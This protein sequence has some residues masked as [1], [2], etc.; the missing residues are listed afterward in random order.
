M[1]MRKAMECLAPYCVRKF[2]SGERG[3]CFECGRALT[4]GGLVF[5]RRTFSDQDYS[6]YTHLECTFNPT[7]VQNHVVHAA[8]GLSESFSVVTIETGLGPF[9]KGRIYQHFNDPK[10]HIEDPSFLLGVRLNGQ[11]QPAKQQP[12]RLEYK[13]AL[14][15][16]VQCHMCSVPISEEFDVRVGALVGNTDRYSKWC[17]LRCWKMP[18][19][20]TGI[21]GRSFQRLQHDR[22][23]SEAVAI[24]DRLMN[25]DCGR[26]Y[27]HLMTASNHLPPPPAAPPPPLVLRVEPRVVVVAARPRVAASSGADEG[28]E[29]DHTVVDPAEAAETE[30]CDMDRVDGVQ[31]LEAGST[32]LEEPSPV[33]PQFTNQLLSPGGTQLPSVRHSPDPFDN[34]SMEEPSAHLE[35]QFTNPPVRHSPDPYDNHSMGDSSA[36]PFF[37]ATSSPTSS[38][39]MMPTTPTTTRVDRVFPPDAFAHF[40]WSKRFVLSG[41]FSKFA[42][43]SDIDT[44]EEGKSRVCDAIQNMGGFVTKKITSDT[45][46]L[47]VGAA[48]GRSKVDAANNR[49]IPILSLDGLREVARGIS[50]Q[51]A[52]RAPPVLHY[53]GG[54]TGNKRS[55]DGPSDPSGPSHPLFSGRPP[56]GRL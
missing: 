51:D 43:A 36:P 3:N 40:L 21:V 1:G 18:F 4:L 26:V 31:E 23:F 47:I 48:P 22:Q 2:S 6:D 56:R 14:E 33:I 5:G 55:R 42:T 38:Q 41:T 27:A 45:T 9:E 15:P 52:R 11:W 25:N 13:G 10:T 54:F 30:Q 46:A 24:D 20:L 7:A 32:Q 29:S 17:H 16:I 37:E 53:S 8:M 49:G 50:L 35:C 34:H 44:L 12:F 39:R 28:V 19:E